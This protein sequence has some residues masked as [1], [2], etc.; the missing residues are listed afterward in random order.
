MQSYIT[1]HRTVQEATSIILDDV[2]QIVFP[3]SPFEVNGKE[4]SILRL[5]D[6]IKSDLLYI[7]DMMEWW[8]EDRE[9]EYWECENRKLFRS[10]LKIVKRTNMSNITLFSLACDEEETTEDCTDMILSY[11]VSLQMIVI[12]LSDW[13]EYLL[14]QERLR[15]GKE[16]THCSLGMFL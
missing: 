10:V 14:S 12:V 11:I 7:R 2:D 4:K 8:L 9:V 6:V 15:I 3:L 16:E 5:A 13:M 1:T